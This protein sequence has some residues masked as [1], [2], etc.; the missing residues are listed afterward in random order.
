MDDDIAPDRPLI[1]GKRS[2]SMSHLPLWVTR[3]KKVRPGKGNRNGKV[4]KARVIERRDRVLDALCPEPEMLLSSDTRLDSSSHAS[5]RIIAKVSGAVP[6]RG[7]DAHAPENGEHVRDTP[8]CQDLGLDH[9]PWLGFLSRSMVTVLC[10]GSSALSLSSSWVHMFSTA[11]N[12]SV[13]VVTLSIISGQRGCHARLLFSPTNGKL[14][15]KASMELGS[16]YGC[17]MLLNCLML[18]MLASY[19]TIATLLL[20]TSR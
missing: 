9:F 15:L 16:R 11:A 1:G 20:Y 12:M 14:Q 19:L 13:T 8:D 17:G 5:K 10:D 7:N 4:S 6:L 18:N 2:L 3:E